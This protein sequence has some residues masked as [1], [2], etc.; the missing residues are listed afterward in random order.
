MPHYIAEIANILGLVGVVL[1]LATY[2]LLQARKIS[3]QDLSYSVVNLLSS[4]FVLCSL[5]FQWNLPSFIIEVV[6]LMISAYGVRQYWTK[7]TV[8]S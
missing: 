3:S 5:I 4:F 1:V 2:F 6:W 8:A 7:R